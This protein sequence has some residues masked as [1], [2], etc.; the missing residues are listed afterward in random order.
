MET[1][2]LKSTGLFNLVKSLQDQDVPI[3]GVGIQ[4]HLTL[5]QFSSNASAGPSLITNLE[6]F[7]NLGIEVAITELDVRI[8]TLPPTREMLIQQK[9][10]Y[11][12]VVD[13]CRQ[14][15][16]CVGVTVWDWTDRVSPLFALS[17]ASW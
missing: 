12:I 9:E 3:D 7:A 10:D 17:V 6:R 8:P 2:N 14:V 4:A 5:G 13:A 16:K 1:V 11:R 15:R